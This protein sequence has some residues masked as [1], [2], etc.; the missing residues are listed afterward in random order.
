[1][2]DTSDSSGGLVVNP[3]REVIL[4]SAE[5][6]QAQLRY[7]ALIADYEAKR[8]TPPSPFDYWTY[9]ALWARAFGAE[10]LVRGGRQQV[11]EGDWHP[12]RMTV[13]RFPSFATALAMYDSP[14]YVA[15]RQLRAGTT[16]CFN[17]VVVEGVDAP[18]A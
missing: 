11:L 12:P 18:P 5:R 3:R 2:P 7:E 15:A 13:L 14:E 16:A 10:Y 9:K 4:T 6:D 1:M 8:T 17:M